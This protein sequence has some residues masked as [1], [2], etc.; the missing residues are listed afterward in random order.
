MRFLFPLILLAAREEFAVEALKEPAPS[1][2]AEA[3]RK[4]LAP[5]GSRVL[6]DGKPFL[7]FWFRTTLPTGEA[8]GGLGI[9]Y[10]TLKPTGLV[11]VAR[12]HGGGSDFKGQKFPA[13]LYTLRY[14]V[15]PEDGDHQGVTESRD[16]LLLTPAASDP[17]PDLL[18]P[19]ELNKL[20]A[21]VNGKKHPAVLYLVGGDGGPLPR[22]VR[23]ATAD[24]SVFEAQVPAAGGK[25][26]RLSIVVQGKAAE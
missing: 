25:L 12:V 4:E 16:F 19:K 15:Q 8:R 20:S 14:G 26:L 10:G 24:R 9:L 2:V 1:E 11:G 21:K 7:D 23:D 13:G 6:R 3:V 5:A 18:D 22:V 17:S